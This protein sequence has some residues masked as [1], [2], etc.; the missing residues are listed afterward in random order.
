MKKIRLGIVGLLVT[1]IVVFSLLPYVASERV[2]VVELH[3][4]DPAGS[5]VTTRLWVV[6]H[7][8]TAYLRVGEN[9]SGWFDRITT[10]KT[11][12]ITRSG[13]CATYR[14]ETRPA[15]SEAANNLMQAKYTW[16]DSL[17]GVL[18]GSRE[19]S[20]PIALVPAD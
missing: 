16:S 18:V 8:G 2:E 6:D 9:V 15:L 3:A 19:G 14:T 10:D 5:G 17:I 11:V 20:I 13:V 4:A 1:L 12:D 7:E